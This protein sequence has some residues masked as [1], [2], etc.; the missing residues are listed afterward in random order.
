MKKNME[1]FNESNTISKKLDLPKEQMVAI[2][3]H[4]K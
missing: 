2:Y 3:H 4:S 1:N